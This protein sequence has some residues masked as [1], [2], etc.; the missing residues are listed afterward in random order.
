MTSDTFGSKEILSPLAGLKSYLDPYP[1][2]A[3]QKEKTRG[4]DGARIVLAL[5][6][7]EWKRIRYLYR[8][9][10]QSRRSGAYDHQTLVRNKLRISESL[11]PRGQKSWSI[12]VC[13]RR[14]LL[15]KTVSSI[16]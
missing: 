5:R 13:C 8:R 6:A 16:H 7:F 12:V 15:T 4:S 1:A 2:L 3:P 9:L 10:E 14:G 11:G